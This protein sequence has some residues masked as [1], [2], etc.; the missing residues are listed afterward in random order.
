MT[1][2]P[3]IETPDELA[4][5]AAEVPGLKVRLLSFIRA[6]VSMHRRRKRQHSPEALKL[7]ERARLEAEQMR[8]DGVTPEQARAEFLKHYLATPR[9]S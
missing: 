5:E 4:R 3:Q 9:I 8:A 7:V 2:F 6:E 1:A